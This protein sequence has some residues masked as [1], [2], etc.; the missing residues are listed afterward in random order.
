M[1]DSAGVTCLSAYSSRRWVQNIFAQSGNWKFVCLQ[2]GILFCCIVA[3]S[4]GKAGGIV[5]RFS[6]FSMLSWISWMSGFLSCR[7]AVKNLLYFNIRLSKTQESRTS[8]QRSGKALYVYVESDHKPLEV[9]LQKPISR[10]PWRAAAP[11]VQDQ[12]HQHHNY[13]VL[14]SWILV[15]HLDCF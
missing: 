7:N 9:I 1:R 3:F 4:V 2:F 6:V 12:K 11:T 8:F 15:E 10:A 13:T 14:V 5:R